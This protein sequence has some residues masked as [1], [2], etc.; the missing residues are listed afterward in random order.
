M[1]ESLVEEYIPMTTDVQEITRRVTGTPDLNMFLCMGPHLKKILE[2]TRFVS[3]SEFLEAFKDTVERLEE[4]LVDSRWFAVTNHDGILPSNAFE[5]MEEHGLKIH[6]PDDMTQCNK[7]SGFFFLLLALSFSERLTNTLAGI[8]CAPTQ[9]RMD[10]SHLRSKV[11]MFDDMSYTGMQASATLSQFHGADVYF[12]CPFIG[13]SA[14]TE[15]VEHEVNV[16]YNERI[17][18]YAE[19]DVGDGMPSMCSYKMNAYPILFQHK[20]ADN[21]SSFPE[22]YKYTIDRKIS[23]PYKDETLF[24]KYAEFV[25][26]LSKKFVF[27]CNKM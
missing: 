2:R 19:M 20:I 6:D 10:C 5:G 21:I 4:S 8:V 22:I 16:I 14:W 15:L 18:T 7:K 11:V 17:P 26:K 9:F 12:A 13:S 1:Y 24:P 25:E 27:A 3:A 23:P